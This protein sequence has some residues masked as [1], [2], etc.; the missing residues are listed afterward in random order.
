[1]LGA[2]LEQEYGGYLC[3]GPPLENGFYYDVFIGEQKITPDQFERIE[4]RVK[5]FVEENHTFQK[6]YLTKEEALSLFKYNP[7]KVQ[8]ITHKIPDNAMVTAY[9]SGSLIDLCTGPH[10]PSSA[11]AKAFKITKSSAA[12]WLGKNTNDDLQRVY[13]VC[14]PTEKQLD[15]YI[16]IQVFFENFS[17]LW[18]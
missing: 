11:K 12:Y 8:L 7:F 18:N 17:F 15:E 14:F 6:V 2:A 3:S 10:I 13:G 9:R 16:K 4:K 5:K 1:M